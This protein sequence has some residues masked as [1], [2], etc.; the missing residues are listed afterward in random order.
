MAKKTISKL[1]YECYDDHVYAL[2]GFAGAAQAEEYVAELVAA[3]AV[4][5]CPG[6]KRVV[7]YGKER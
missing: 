7:D 6:C 1:C 2:I 3:R 4:V 5:K